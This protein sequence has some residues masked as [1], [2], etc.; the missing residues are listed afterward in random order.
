MASDGEERL[1]EGLEGQAGSPGW[2]G[3][4]WGEPPKGCKQKGKRI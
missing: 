2:P 4:Q 1:R 3:R